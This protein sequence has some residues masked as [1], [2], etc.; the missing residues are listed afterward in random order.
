MDTGPFVP[1][2][3]GMGPFD[4]HAL[5]GPKRLRARRTAAP[6]PDR[7]NAPPAVLTTGAAPAA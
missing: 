7:M 3:V 5:A 2:V 4:A 1:T 6:W